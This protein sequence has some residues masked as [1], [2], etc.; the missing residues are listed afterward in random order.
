MLLQGLE[1]RCTRLVPASPCHDNVCVPQ[2]RISW[3]NNQLKMLSGDRT[4]L[5]SSVRSRSALVSC[6]DRV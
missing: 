6:T 1:A 2:D 4:G 3:N 5:E